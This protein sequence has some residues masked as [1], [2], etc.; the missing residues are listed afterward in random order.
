M[1]KMFSIKFSLLL[2]IASVILTISFT[3]AQDATGGSDNSTA[4]PLPPRSKQNEDAAM[5]KLVEQEEADLK[6][7]NPS[8]TTA[9]TQ[10][11]AH[12]FS[13]RSNFGIA[14][15]ISTKSANGTKT[16]STKKVSNQLNK[17]SQLSAAAKAKL[18]AVL[19]NA[20]KL[21]N[22]T[23]KDKPKKKVEPIVKKLLNSTANI[24]SKVKNATTK[25]TVSPQEEEIDIPIKTADDLIEAA[26]LQRLRDTKLAALKARVSKMRYYENFKCAPIPTPVSTK[27]VRTGLLPALPGR[28][29]V[30]SVAGSAGA[31]GSS[32]SLT[33]VPEKVVSGSSSAESSTTTI[34]TT[35]ALP[36]E[37]ASVDD[38]E[39]EP[40]CEL[41]RVA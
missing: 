10:Q 6:N 31:G 40:V 30:N 7:N 24:T 23:S 18:K 5:E 35:T 17:K 38:A 8:S 14:K 34:T 25:S 13:K 12:A 26:V 16:N 32:S 2:L 15:K 28:N 41:K 20:S 36:S 3:I 33:A 1:T 37:D 29:S 21:G 27:L 22:T 4:P 9:T 19:L 11:K 39:I